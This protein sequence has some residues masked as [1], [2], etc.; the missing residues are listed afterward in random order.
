[1]KSWGQVLSGFRLNKPYNIPN[2]NPIAQEFHNQSP[3]ENDPISAKRINPVGDHWIPANIC[4]M[5]TFSFQVSSSQ[6]NHLQ[7]KIWG[8]SIEQN[9][10]FE[11]LCAIIWHCIAH[12]RG[13][14]ESNI[15]TI[16]K[17][18]PFHSG[19][20][21]IG[22]NQ[23]ITK[24]EADFDIV[25]TG[26]RK[27]AKTLQEV[28]DERK[29]IEEAVEKDH[30]VSDFFIYGANLTFVDL[31]GADLYDVEVRGRKPKFI[32]HSI[33]GVGD[34]GVVIVQPLSKGSIKN[35]DGDGGKFVTIILPEDQIEKFK[36]EL[37]R[38]DLM[39]VGELK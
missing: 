37:K 19:N 30:G 23:L 15:V 20:D 21:F 22:N 5:D 29:K 39:L 18:D 3:T 31:D 28:V 36:F 9:K 38:N 26:L 8:Q 34:E 10:T 32:Y 2:P 35:H 33:Q 4:K 6:L 7:A 27:L 12:A 24:V 16:C 11:S 14:S 17:K 13:R 25:E 1:M